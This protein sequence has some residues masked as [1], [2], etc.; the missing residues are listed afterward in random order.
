MSRPI[1]CRRIE[2]LP[3]FRSFSP[4]DIA[5]EEQV[6][7]TVDEFE[8]IRL[9]DNEGLTQEACAARMNIART[10]VTAIYDSARQKLAD[11]LVNGKRLLITGGHCEV[12]PVVIQQTL[13]EK[14]S[15][16]MRIAVAY[17]NG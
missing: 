15:I 2:R 9:L 5:A 12:E 11:A 10:T 7:M 17:E 3:V 13:I 8:T 6:E 16:T 1:R 4:D 14:G